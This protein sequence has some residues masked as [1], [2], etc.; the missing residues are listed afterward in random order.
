MQRSYKGAFTYGHFFDLYNDSKDKEVIIIILPECIVSL[1]P[2]N[3]DLVYVR[4]VNA[5]LVFPVLAVFL[6]R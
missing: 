6:L 2:L 3:D 1:Q 5:L 4:V